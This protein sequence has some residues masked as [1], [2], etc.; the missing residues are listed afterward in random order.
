MK[1]NLFLIYKLVQSF[2][3]NNFQFIQITD[4]SRMKLEASSLQ[5]LW[6]VHSPPSKVFSRSKKKRGIYYYKHRHMQGKSAKRKSYYA[7]FT[8]RFSF[9]R[10]MKTKI[11]VHPRYYGEGEKIL[12]N[13]KAAFKNKQISFSFFFFNYT[14]PIERKEHQIEFLWEENY[15]RHPK[16]T[17]NIFAFFSFQ[18]NRIFKKLKKNWFGF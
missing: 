7:E 16:W 12:R 4:K 14:E 1:E 3:L 17:E 5:C 18:T 8:L 10:R 6:P 15:C 11:I 2:S 9:P 13:T